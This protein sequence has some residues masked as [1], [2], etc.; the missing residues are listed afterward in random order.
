MSLKILL[1]G[2]IGLL[3][4]APFSAHA[5][6]RRGRAGVVISPYGVLYNTRSPEWQMAGGNPIL[7]QQ[8]LAQKQM[9]FEQRMMMAQQKQ[10]MLA[11]R[12]NRRWNQ[13]AGGWNGPARGNP[14]S[15]LAAGNTVT[16]RRKTK[17][18]TAPLGDVEAATKL[19]NQLSGP[20][21]ARPVGGAVT[22]PAP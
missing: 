22:A 14:G 6:Y 18:A 13:A 17:P 12:R 5:Q 9:I 8:L 15:D 7:Y 1:A 3:L 2:A 21:G 4:V 16:N 20:P 11:Q 10:F 19:K